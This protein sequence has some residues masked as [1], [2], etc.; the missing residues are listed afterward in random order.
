MTRRINYEDDI[1]TVALQVRCLQDALKLEVD[2]ELFKDRLL[3]DA[4]WID[5]IS[6]RLYQSLRDSALFVH[7][8]EHLRELAKLKRAFA[9]A[10]DVI[11]EGKAPIAEHMADRVESLKKMRDSHLRDIN[12]IKVL[13]DGGGTPEEEHIVSAEE[14]KF[15]MTADE[16]EE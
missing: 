3:G 13:L 16:E 5:A 7:R 11:V 8:Q 12:E 14:L 10:L 4:A 15:L 1:F 6:A 2:P 9:D